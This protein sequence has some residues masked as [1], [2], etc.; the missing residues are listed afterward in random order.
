MGRPFLRVIAVAGAILALVGLSR[1]TQVSI[2][3]QEPGTAGAAKPGAAPTTAWG[4][5]DLQGIWTAEY[6]VPLERAAKFADREF[7]TEAEVADLDKSRA[8]QPTFSVRTKARGTEHDLAGAYSDDFQSIRRSGRRTSLIVDPP[9]GRIPPLTPDAQKRAEETQAYRTALLQAVDLCKNGGKDTPACAGVN[10]T[11]QRS[12][13]RAEPPPHYPMVALN[14]GDGPEDRG[15][16]ERCLSGSLL[17]FAAYPAG[18]RHIVQSPASVS[19]FYDV[20][21][22]QGQVRVIPITTQPHVPSNVRLWW[23]DSRG[24]WE[25]DTLVV[26]VTNFNAKR[27]FQGSR[28]NLHLTERWRRIDATTLEYSVTLEDP[29]TWARPWTIRQEL[30]LQDAQ[31]NRIYYEPRCHEGNYAMPTMLAGARMEDKAFAEGRGPDPSKKCYIV[32]LPRVE[33]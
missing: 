27:E 10:F 24:R 29:T 25:G 33:E 9:N 3:G 5:P 15:L 32:C 6:F 17:D 13:R 4:A 19:I 16:G 22:G 8:A 2:V 12:P 28:E 21:Q 23:G 18:F 1:L 7:L 30:N 31:Q 20:G 11:G 14:R 26:D